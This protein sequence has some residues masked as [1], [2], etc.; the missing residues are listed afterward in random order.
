M[1]ELEVQRTALPRKE[2][3]QKFNVK[4]RL[5]PVLPDTSKGEGLGG[6]GGPQAATCMLTKMN[7]QVPR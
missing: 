1:S 2:N 3:V 4:E 5:I 7:S 6:G